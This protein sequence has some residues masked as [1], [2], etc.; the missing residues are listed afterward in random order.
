MLKNTICA[1]HE[2][3]QEIIFLGRKFKVNSQNYK[4]V[5]SL[6]ILHIQISKNISGIASLPLICVART[7]I[8]YYCHNTEKIKRIVVTLPLYKVREPLGRSF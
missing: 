5:F 6:K 7:T 4:S 8:S 3:I 2:D 1:H